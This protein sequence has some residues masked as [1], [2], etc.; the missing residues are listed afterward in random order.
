[1]GQRQRASW[2]QCSNEKMFSQEPNQ[3]L[4]IHSVLQRNR[5]GKIRS[6]RAV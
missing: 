3:Y 5:L 1:M 4:G 2:H 6:A